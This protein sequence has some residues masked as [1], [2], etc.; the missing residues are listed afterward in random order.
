MVMGML[1]AG[2]C[3]RSHPP[4]EPPERERVIVDGGGER[5]SNRDDSDLAG[6]A[7]WAA[8]V[9]TAQLSVGANHVCA[10]GVDGRVRCWGSGEGGQLGDGS[11]TSSRGWVDVSGL[12]DARRV[13]A[14]GGFTCAVRSD[15]SVACWGGLGAGPRPGSGAGVAASTTPEPVP[16]LH[17]AVD[18]AS[19]AALACALDARGRARCW[20][21][22]AGGLQARL[23]GLSRLVQI[24]AGYQHACGLDRDGAVHCWGG[25]DAGQL[26]DGSRERA[27]APVRVPLDRPA[28]AIATGDAHTC[29]L[30]NDGT[31][32]CWGSNRYGQLGDG[33]TVDRLTPASVAGLTDVTSVHAGRHTCAVTRGQ[34]LCW[35]ENR[36]GELYDGTRVPRA[37]PHATRIAG[38]M[39]V[40]AVT[41]CSE[42][43]ADTIECCGRVTPVER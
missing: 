30:M 38:R 26:G 28:V 23:D 34:T 27:L 29:A 18:V 11:R 4:E 22:G 14:G 31:L 2:G 8:P 6:C 20:G 32:S 17:D 16:G 15:G 12:S 40:H 42:R 19:G 21:A 35:G 5:A 3:T 39:D 41:T 7:T 36:Y 24:D 33:T 10:L 37:R 25:N 13:S 43:A 1:L 9:D